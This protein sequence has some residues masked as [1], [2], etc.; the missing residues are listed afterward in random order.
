[1]KQTIAPED[2][3]SRLFLKAQQY[4]HNLKYD[5]RGKRIMK[6]AMRILTRLEP[7]E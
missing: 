3:A 2:K 5:S 7:T 4:C 1:M 6:H